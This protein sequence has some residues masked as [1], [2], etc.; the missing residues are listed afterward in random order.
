MSGIEY[1]G[2]VFFA[3]NTGDQDLV[4]K[5]KKTLV[6]NGIRE[7]DI[8]INYNTAELEKDDLYISYDPPHLIVRM[9]YEKTSNGFV[10]MKTSSMIKLH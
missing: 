9:V 5:A 2:K 8:Q 4:I 7:E 1:H 6:E 3:P 10:K